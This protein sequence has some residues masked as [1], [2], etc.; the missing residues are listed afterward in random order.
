MSVFPVTEMTRLEGWVHEEA[1]KALCEHLM[2][3]YHEPLRIYYRGCSLYDPAREPA[4][5]VD[6]FFV[7]C[8]SGEG[9]VVAYLRTWMEGRKGK[10]RDYLINGL[11]F[12]M[13][14]DRGVAARERDRRERTVGD[15]A[16][17]EVTAPDEPSIDFDR[18]YIKNVVRYSLVLASRRCRKEG[19]SDHWRIF[20]RHALKDQPYARIAPRLRVSEARAAV[21][22]R[23]GKRRF[24]EEFCALIERD[25]PNRASCEE[26]IRTYLEIIDS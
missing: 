18:A 4:E 21:M 23:T 7:R 8:L 6:T 14:T 10:L 19:Y 9:G 25:G 1:S 13:K 22:L 16:A 17:A 5:V 15:E 3:V 24:I 2:S 20:V 26:T 12:S 11:W